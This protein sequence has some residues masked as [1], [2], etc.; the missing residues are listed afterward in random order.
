MTAPAPAAVPPDA[1]DAPQGA[2]SLL[3]IMLPPLIVIE[4]AA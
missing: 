2:E 4:G 1:G 3:I